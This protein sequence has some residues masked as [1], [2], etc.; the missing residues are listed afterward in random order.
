MWQRHNVQ[1]ANF[2]VTSLRVIWFRRSSF[3]TSGHFPLLV[4]LG[5]KVSQWPNEKE[6]IPAGCRG[7]QAKIFARGSYWPDTGPLLTA[8][9]HLVKAFS[10]CKS[11]V[12]KMNG[13]I[14]GRTGSSVAKQRRRR[15]VMSFEMVRLDPAS[16][17][18]LYQ[19]LYRQIR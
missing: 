18:P 13:V 15:L 14:Y 5:V 2:D 6:I 3:L 11:R 7:K 17:E 12:G 16:S 9:S 8:A 19:Q 4:V 10:G 1:L